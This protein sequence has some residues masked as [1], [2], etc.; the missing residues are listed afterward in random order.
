[1]EKDSVSATAAESSTSQQD[2][3]VA[4]LMAPA[5][6]AEESPTLQKEAENEAENEAAKD[7]AEPVTDSSA[8]DSSPSQTDVAQADVEAPTNT[9][10][11]WSERELYAVFSLICHREHLQKKRGKNDWASFAKKLNDLLSY[12]DYAGTSPITAE[13]AEEV[14][15]KLYISRKHAMEF[16]ER[17]PPPFVPTKK[18]YL[19]F[20]REIPFNG[21]KEEWI[22]QGR[23]QKAAEARRKALEEGRIVIAPPRDNDTFMS[24]AGRLIDRYVPEGRSEQ[25]TQDK[26]GP[27]EEMVDADSLAGQSKGRNAEKDDREAKIQAI[28]RD[29]DPESAKPAEPQYILGPPPPPGPPA[30]PEPPVATSPGQF[31]NLLRPDPRTYRW[32]SQFEESPASP[33]S[34]KPYSEYT[35]PPPPT[36]PVASPQHVRAPD[37]RPRFQHRKR[38]EPLNFGS[39]VASSSKRGSQGPSGPRPSAELIEHERQYGLGPDRHEAK[40]RGLGGADKDKGKNKDKNK[41]K[42]KGKEKD[43]TNDKTEESPDGMYDSEGFQ[44]WYSPCTPKNADNGRAEGSG[45]NK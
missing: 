27:D 24:L 10:R 20:R 9:A 25:G 30:S 29:A 2:A 32:K 23:K 18:K 28:I 16:I 22:I 45:K 7:A 26:Q 42:G 34:D 43:S 3:Q 17:Q 40:L 41:G 36:T 12:H 35:I 14:I 44:P 13:D 21:S 38:R 8:K 6:P 1:M 4:S 33:M 5:T 19:V 11:E 15:R 37:P 39:T 31:K